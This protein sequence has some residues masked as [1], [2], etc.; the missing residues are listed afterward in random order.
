MF[1]LDSLRF[2]VC[3][4]PNGGQHWTAMEETAA[5]SKQKPQQTYKAIQRWAVTN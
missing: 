5:L 4:W 1:T 2:L 3:Y